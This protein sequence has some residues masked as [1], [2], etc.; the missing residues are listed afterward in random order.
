MRNFDE[1]VG[2]RF[3]YRKIQAMTSRKKQV[4]IGGNK[5]A[6]QAEEEDDIISADLSETCQ[7]NSLVDGGN[8][9]KYRERKSRRHKSKCRDIS[10]KIKE[11]ATRDRKKSKVKYIVKSPLKMSEVNDQPM[12][13]V[14][15][16]SRIH[17][18]AFQSDQKTKASPNDGAYDSN[19]N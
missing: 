11:K 18:I 8:Y 17:E 7:Q 2:S 5:A 14:A 1:S 6:F 15:Q 19:N 3:S 9:S 16:S 10:S 4:H 12:I 13:I